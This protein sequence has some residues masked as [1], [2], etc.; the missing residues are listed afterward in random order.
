[1][2]YDFQRFIP[3]VKVEKAD[4]GTCKVVGYAST[5]ALDLDGEI[6]SKQAVK[7]ALPSYWEWRNIR[8]MH[9]PKAV[10]RAQDANVDDKGL[11]LTAK[12]V[13]P[14]AVRKCLDKVLQGFSIGGRKLNKVDNVITELEM[15]EISLVDRPANPEC[16]FDVAKRV[17]AGAPAVLV[18]V[19]GAARDPSRRALAK[20]AKAIELLSKDG[21]PAAHDG[22]SLPAKVGGNGNAPSPKDPDFQANKGDG[23]ADESP[24]LLNPDTKKRNVSR[25]ERKRLARQ[26]KALPSGGFPIENESDLMN[27]RHAVGRAKNPGAARSLIRRRA[28]ELGVKLPNKWTKKVARKAIA[29]A[30]FAKK[31]AALE[32]SLPFLTLPGSASS[33]GMGHDGSVPPSKLPKRFRKGGEAKIKPR[34]LPDYWEPIVCND[35]SIIGRKAGRNSPETSVLAD[36]VNWGLRLE[37]LEAMTKEA[38]RNGDDIGAALAKLITKAAEPTPEQRIAAARGNL[39]KARSARKDAMGAVK[40]CHAMLKG[41]FLAKNATNDDDADDKNKDNFDFEKALTVL[42]KAASALVAQST[43]HKAVKEQLRKAAGGLVGRSGQRG[44]Q[45]TD[46]ESPHYTAPPGLRELSPR[47]LATAGPG[48]GQHGSEP[49]MYPDDGSVYPGKAARKMAKGGFVSTDTAEALARAAA[50]EAKVE[51]LE[52]IPTSGR[53]PHAFDVAKAFGSGDPEEQRRAKILYNGVDPAALMSED[54]SAHKSATARMIGNMLT[55]PEFANS[56]FDTKFHGTAGIGR[57]SL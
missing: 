10:G 49:P 8:E 22:F 4:D 5:E 35:E 20:M 55:S 30:E 57:N 2:R 31:S 24:D 21:P 51:I 25:K 14:I 6:V 12:I 42:N 39:K 41:A 56:V 47:D 54:E 19:A 48:G 26:G 17:K 16:R 32:H 44:E 46:G 23:I 45:P 29:R 27:A 43:L 18:K 15:V 50:A 37:D 11:F 3:F 9:Q 13:D 36:A 33:P 40:E 52:R 38:K 34:E 28:R 7:N 53:R 1:M